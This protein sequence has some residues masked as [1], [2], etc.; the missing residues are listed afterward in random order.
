MFQFGNIFKSDFFP[1][2]KASD[3]EEKISN[4]NYPL[5]DFL[6]DDEAITTAKF[7]GKNFQ[8]YLN[9]GKLKKLIKLITEEPTKDDHLHGHKFPYVASQ[10]LKLDIPFIAKR[11]VLNEQE[12]DEEYPESPE[13]EDNDIIES[14]SE[15]K[16]IEFDLKRNKTE[17]EKIYSQI[18]ESFRNLRNSVN[19]DKKEKRSKDD[20]YRDEYLSDE[21]DNDDEEHYGDDE[22]NL[23]DNN[24]N[25]DNAIDD[26]NLELDD[27]EEKN[28]NKNG[29]NENINDNKENIEENNNNMDIEKTDKIHIIENDDKNIYANEIINE[30][31]NKD[32]NEIKHD[33]KENLISIEKNIEKNFDDNFEK[34]EQIEEKDN[35]NNNDLTENELKDEKKEEEKIEIKEG[36]IIQKD[37]NNS[38]DKF[39][40]NQG[41]QKV[42]QNEFENDEK[43]KE[44]NLDINKKEKNKDIIKEENND[45]IHKAENEEEKVKIENEE[46]ME[47]NKEDI[48][49]NK[50]EVNNIKIE[51]KQDIVI[52]KETDIEDETIKMENKEEKNEDIEKEKSED[53][54]EEKNKEVNEEKFEESKEK[55]DQSLNEENVNDIKEKKVEEI[56]EEKNEEII[57]GKVKDEKNEEVKDEKNEK[58]GE[59]KNEKN[60]EIKEDKVKE[61]KEEGKESQ[62]D[63]KQEIN[64]NINES[65]QKI[66]KENIE[67]VNNK[68]DEK[69]IPQSNP[70]NKEEKEQEEEINEEINNII[71]DNNEEDKQNIKSVETIENDNNNEIE[72]FKEMENDEHS[73]SV[74]GE[75]EEIPKPI[76]KKKIYK[77]TNKNEYLDLLLNFV[78]NDKPEL[79][80]VLAGYFANVIIT[81][82]NKYPY[83]I[84]KYLYTQRRDAIKKIIL[85]SNQKAFAILAARILNLE[86]F[87]STEKGENTKYLNEL[88]QE[89]INYRNEL[90]KEVLNLLT[91]DGLKDPSTNAINKGVDVEGIFS[92]II[93]LIEKKY[94]VEQLI[95]GEE[96]YLCPYLFEILESDLYSEENI[97]SENFDTKYTIYGLF[98][99]LTSKLIKVANSQCSSLFPTNFNFNAISKQKNENTFNDNMIISFGKILKNNFLAKKPVLILEKM[100]YLCYEG[101]GALNIQ[102]LDLVIN[103]ISFMDYLPNNIFDNILI[104]NNFCKNGIEYFFKYQWNDLYLT[105]FTDFFDKIL[106]NGI[107]HEALIKYFFEHIKI[108]NLLSNYLEEKNKDNNI[109]MQ[110]IKYEFKSGNAIKS[111]IYPHVIEL[112]YK[113]QAYAGLDT[114]TKEEIESIKIINLGE[115]E[116]V[117]DETS[118]KLINIFKTSDS[119]KNILSKDE[120]WLSMFKNIA[121]PLIKKYENKLCKTVKP[122][123]D[124]DDLFDNKNDYGSNGLLLQ[125]MLNVLKKSSPL[126]RFSLP[127]SRNDKNQPGA[128]NKNKNNIK[129]SIREK[130]LNKGYKS[131]HILDDDEDDENKNEINNEGNDINELN[132]DSKNENN[133]NYYDTNYWELKNDLPEKIKKEVDKKTNI[134]FNYNP[135]TGE[136]EKKNE[137]SEEDELL[138]VAM[139]LEQNE[140][141]EKNK[142]I[143]Y[144]MP[145]KIKPI[146]LKTKSN[147]AQNIFFKIPTG[148]NNNKFDK[149]RNKKK[150]LVMFDD[151]EDDKDKDKDEEDE[152]NIKEVNIINDE[153]NKKDEDIISINKEEESNDDNNKE[154]DKMFNDVNFW[155]NNE[156][157]L[158]EKEMEDLINE[159]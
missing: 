90:I 98:I 131:R 135:I 107:K 30:N 77:N 158:N 3:L 86:E 16:E 59:V 154:E 81:L 144:I 44:E 50:G 14:S 29:K 113:I 137:I 67:E 17:F 106:K 150:D 122:A 53:K 149:L 42:N 72:N 101:L 85:H 145:G 132:N 1:M 8:K 12:Y 35:I 76:K 83:R 156:N 88:I 24:N 111:G 99:N 37:I 108:Q 39:N 89:N 95:Y 49:E 61:V 32:E 57:E 123:E 133:K 22:E 109:I 58:N 55:K 60:E 114:F 125:Q 92:L 96:K 11:F 31:I 91:L 130:L 33:N 134:I 28:I 66:S 102:I 45:D 7:M 5:E 157:Y 124:E 116:F 74:E 115:F 141:V 23:K 119:L 110:K 47:L 18:E 142:K 126:K 151:I 140:K 82:L 43:T 100:S 56:K 65:S 2:N 87:I 118:N 34:K 79:N 129:I 120:N 121:L 93:E 146:N 73:L 46:K 143:M 69:N 9:P 27:E 153:D 117:K 104:R 71:V 139:E 10:I 38:D 6:K 105:K 84:L 54:K 26:I 52:S 62:N 147:P 78:M 63:E 138:S 48:K 97:K 127:L 152:D 21:K 136:N 36:E 15:Q 159:L 128:I 25:S 155:K 4:I 68:Q 40:E 41:I 13:E 148:K 112:I 80:Y 94:I 75:L 19:S 20:T 64:N 103:M 51:E 70:I